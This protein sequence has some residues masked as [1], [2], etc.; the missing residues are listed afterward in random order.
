MFYVRDLHRG[1]YAKDKVQIT[2]EAAKDA[3]GW[4]LMSEHLRERYYE[5]GYEKR[6]KRE[7]EN[8]E[9]KNI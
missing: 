3:Q 6:D 7:R 8:N 5:L 4:T 9:I 2:L 1:V